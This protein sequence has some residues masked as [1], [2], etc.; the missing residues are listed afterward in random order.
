MLPRQPLK[1]VCLPFHHLGVTVLG[2]RFELSR[3]FRALASE[4]SVSTEGSTTRATVLAEGIEPPTSW[5]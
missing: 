5:V 4:A 3:L 1:L 2:E